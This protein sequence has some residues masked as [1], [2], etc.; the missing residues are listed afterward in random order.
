M[1]W[2]C[3]LEDEKNDRAAVKGLTQVN[4]LADMVTLLLDQ[5]DHS[6][7]STTANLEMKLDN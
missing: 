4:R 1:S 2:R 3:S 7:I 6:L 5:P